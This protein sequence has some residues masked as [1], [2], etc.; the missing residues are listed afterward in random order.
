MT[1]CGG[2]LNF[3][4]TAKPAH[5]VVHPSPSPC[6]CEIKLKTF[7]IQSIVESYIPPENRSFPDTSFHAPA[8]MFHLTQ[9][10]LDRLIGEIL[11]IL[12]LEE[13]A[14]LN[15]GL[16]RQVP[17]R[18]TYKVSS[19]RLL[20]KI[21]VRLN[22]VAAKQRA[23]FKLIEERRRDKLFSNFL[24]FYLRGCRHEFSSK[25]RQHRDV[26]NFIDD[27]KKI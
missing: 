8:Q 11:F 12:D 20:G 13:A 25:S 2:T 16:F 6:L 9:P 3:M 22:L 26:G 27:M 24:L 23:I 7:P 14:A 10:Y 15:P 1:V 17:R 18:A 21:P 19:C 4:M 5:A